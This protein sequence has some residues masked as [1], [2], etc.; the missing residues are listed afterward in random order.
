MG[1]VNIAPLWIG[2][3]KQLI[4]LSTLYNTILSSP[5]LMNNLVF[6]LSVPLKIAL[7]MSKNIVLIKYLILCIKQRCLILSTRIPQYHNYISNI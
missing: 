2:H 3:L 5:I 7:P 4:L 6:L 1:F